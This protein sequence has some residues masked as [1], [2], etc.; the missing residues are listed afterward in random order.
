M[1][2]GITLNAEAGP[3]QRS[4]PVARPRL[5]ATGRWVLGVT[6]LVLL[7]TLLLSAFRFLGDPTRFPVT[8]VDV[9]GT[10]DFTERDVLRAHVERHTRLGFYGFDVDALH[11]DVEAMPW[12]ASVRVRRVW[13]ASVTVEIDEHEPV[14]R[15]NR[16]ALISKRDQLFEPPQLEMDAERAQA[17]RTVFAELPKLAGAEGREQVLLDAWRRYS[18]ELAPFE[19]S[20]VSLEEDKRHS[21]TL[22]LSNHVRVRLGVAERNERLARFLDVYARLVEPLDGRSARFD[23][24]YSNGFAYR[25]PDVGANEQSSLDR[26]G[27]GSHG[28]GT[29]LAHQSTTRETRAWR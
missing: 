27:L 6:G 21:Q 3:R 13:P 25:G 17:W 15:W 4:L 24:R 22:V 26:W 19:V 11:R 14:A 7:T 1:N 18:A 23:M 20:L 29:R 8:Q 9:L 16:N 10:L 2:P 12:V 28:L 5:S